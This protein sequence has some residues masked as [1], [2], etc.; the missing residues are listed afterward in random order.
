MAVRPGHQLVSPTSPSIGLE[1][2]DDAR[3]RGPALEQHVRI[4][5]ERAT[6][7]LRP[8]LQA[9]MTDEA[10]LAGLEALGRALA[11]RHSGRRFIF[12]TAPRG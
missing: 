8:R 2:H 6:E 1:E 9:P 12:E 5:S 7:N 10:L 11:R 3:H 4:D